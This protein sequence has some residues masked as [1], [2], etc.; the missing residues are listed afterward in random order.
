MR[1]MRNLGRNRCTALPP[2]SSRR[3]LTARLASLLTD[4]IDPEL[5]DAAPELKVISNC[6]SVSKNIDIPAAHGALAS[7]WEH[8]PC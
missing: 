7:R 1:A 8:A 2:S 5:L 4:K 3:S 6:A